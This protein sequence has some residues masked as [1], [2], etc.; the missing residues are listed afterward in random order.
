M[1]KNISKKKLKKYIEKKSKQL[2]LTPKKWD[3]KLYPKVLAKQ[4]RLVQITNSTPAEAHIKALLKKTG[5]S[6]DYQYTIFFG[7][8][9]FYILDFYLPKY[10][11]C[12]EVDGSHH[13]TDEKQVKHD[14][15]RT[16]RLY[17]KGITVIRIPNKQALE[18]TEETFGDFLKECL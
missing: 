12:I 15:L 10:K 9:Q 6:F 1:G 14:E 17:N 16:M 5:Y 7:N 2:G 18:H 8:F 11:V 4:R 13:Y 3:K